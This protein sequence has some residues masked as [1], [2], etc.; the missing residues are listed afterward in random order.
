M[1]WLRDF[2]CSPRE[3]SVSTARSTC[4]RRSATAPG[5]A[6]RRHRQASRR[7]LIFFLFSS[8]CNPRR[9]R[10]CAS[11]NATPL[12]ARPRCAF[13]AQ[14]SLAARFQTPTQEAS[15]FLALAR[16]TRVESCSQRRP[17]VHSL[18]MFFSGFNIFEEMLQMHYK[19][20]AHETFDAFVAYRT[21]HIYSPSYY[22]F[23]FSMVLGLVPLQ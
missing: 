5:L 13:L 10:G 21:I 9:P 8:I 3:L 19:T 17:Y 6:A 18:D 16:D 20:T 12:S 15:D 4:S 2:L 7:F 22:V 1:V 14:C 23:S 11:C